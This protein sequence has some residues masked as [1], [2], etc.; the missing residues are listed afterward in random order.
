MA[1]LQRPALTKATKV[2]VAIGLT[3]CALGIAW[4]L[5]LRFL[6]W[7]IVYISHIHKGNELIAR[8]EAFKSQHGRLPDPANVN[9][10]LKLASS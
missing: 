5:A 2:S 7:D 9:E 1:M 3:I 8:V 4:F 10:V 6:P